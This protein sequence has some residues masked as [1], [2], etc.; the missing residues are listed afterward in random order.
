MYY[1]MRS[2]IR[3]RYKYIF[4][5]AHQLPYPFASDLYDSP[6]WQGVLKRGDKRYGRRLTQDYIQ[7]PRHEL[8]DLEADPD[9]LENLA[10]KP[11]H[12]KLLAELQERVRDWQK[13]TADP[14]ELKWRYE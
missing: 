10:G 11:E 13:R 7:R 14:W 12:A 1:P 5:V 8:C 9:E 4:N 3:G 2:V 6:T